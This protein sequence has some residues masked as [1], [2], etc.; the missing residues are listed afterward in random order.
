MFISTHIYIL[1]LYENAPHQ[2]SATL[3][4]SQPSIGLDLHLLAAGQG[5]Q[6]SVLVCIFEI[7]ANW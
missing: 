2:K 3:E 6:Q 1:I 5:A 7:S 4:P